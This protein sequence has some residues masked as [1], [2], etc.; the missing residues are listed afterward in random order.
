MNWVK[1]AAIGAAAAL[2]PDVALATFAWQRNWVPE[3]DIRVKAHRFLHSTKGLI[4]LVSV[5]AASHIV[6]DWLSPHRSS[7]DD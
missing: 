4:W 3:S 6:A 5:A 1:H 2:L 7:L